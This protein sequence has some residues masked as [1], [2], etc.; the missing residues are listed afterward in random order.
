M[1]RKNDQHRQQRMF[2]VVDQ[3]SKSAK[4]KLDTS[5]A[6]VFY[7][8]YF[9]RLDESVFSVLYSTKKSRPNTPINLLVAFET[10]KSGFSISDEKLYNH[11]LFDLQ[12]RYALGLHDF[13]EGHFEL[14][15]IYN[16]RAALA[17]YEAEHGVNLIRLASEQITDEQ[18]KQFQMRTGL[19]RMDSTMV[20]SNIR[21]M[22]RLQLLVE[23]IHRFHRM[24]SENEKKKHEELFHSYIKQD[25]LHYCYK[26]ER[27]EVAGRVENLGCDLAKMLEIFHGRYGAE[28][29]YLDAKQVF[30][31]H[32]CIKESV[33][34]K[35]KKE[36]NGRCLQS[37]DDAEATFRTKSRESSRGYVANI[38]ETCDSKN[39][40]QLITTVSVA[41]NVTD[42]QELLVGDVE[43]LS[44]RM[45]LETLLSDAGYTGAVAADAVTKHNVELKVS[46][47]KGRKKKY[48]NTLGLEDFRLSTDESGEV[49]EIVCPQGFSGE[50]RPTKTEHRFTAGFDG[51]DCEV[52]PMK[53]DC[54]AKRL[55]KRNLFVL[56]FTTS[57]VRVA[58]QRMQVAECGRKVLNKR[59]S[60]E[61]TVRSV[62]HPFGGHLCKMPVR[63][64][65]R[66]TNMTILSAMMV[67]VHRITR[68][69]NPPEP[70]EPIN[71]DLATI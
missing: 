36:L 52:C 50:V 69:L 14:R 53:E 58:Q 67:N 4:H 26:L 12:F 71:R 24:L 28:K 70:I 35:D 57:D 37:P 15:T 17:A 68:Y 62:I 55:K 2:T 60:V 45:E 9:C 41:P 30:R 3:L 61:S 42:D 5:W 23:I 32:F 29:G 33:S 25:S 6:P 44:D 21:K 48:A 1:F 47:I 65:H 54:P 7:Q 43:N 56:H 11:F 13:D 22:S 10:L 66:I 46:G 64:R 63:G 40:L 31:E 49:K 34:I 16:F 20:Q 51:S 8:E 59:A 39:E 38:T 27:D 19:Q 18:L